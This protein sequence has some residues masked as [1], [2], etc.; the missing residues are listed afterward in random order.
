[1]NWLKVNW[2]KFSILCLIISISGLALYW[3]SYKPSSD[4]KWCYKI[5][6]Y[7]KTNAIK[8]DNNAEGY[9]MLTKRADYSKVFDD[10]YKDCLREKGL[11]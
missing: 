6:G 11:Q 5:A 8:M 9:G 7:T 4:R 3:F 10:A 1:M 2:F